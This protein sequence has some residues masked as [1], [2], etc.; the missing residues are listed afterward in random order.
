[1]ADVLPLGP[2]ARNLEHRFVEVDARDRTVL[3]IQRQVDAGADAHLEY[4]FT[5]LDVHPIDSAKAAGMERWAEGEIVH[6][7]NFVVDGANEIV[8]NDRH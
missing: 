7:G 6:L 8:F 4:A 1:V 3:R 5:G 2:L